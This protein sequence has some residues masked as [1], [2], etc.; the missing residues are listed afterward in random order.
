MISADFLF[1]FHNRLEYYLDLMDQSWGYRP[2]IEV[3]H[4]WLARVD[5]FYDP[6][7]LTINPKTFLWR[8]RVRK[9]FIKQCVSNRTR[10]PA[11][12]AL[13]IFEPHGKLKKAGK[14]KEPYKT[15]GAWLDEFQKE[16]EIMRAANPN[17]KVKVEV[18]EGLCITVDFN[19]EGFAH[20]G[21]T[22]YVTSR[23]AKANRKPESVARMFVAEITSHR[24]TCGDCGVG[25]ATLTCR[26]KGYAW[27]GLDIDAPPDPIEEKIHPRLSNMLKERLKKKG[28]N[29]I[30]CPTKRSN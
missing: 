11:R 16:F 25:I 21:Q 10:T 26:A 12:I 8:H 15:A 14:G 5:A 19:I 23:T 1:R 6:S 13:S 9:F 4:Q 3:S 22:I 28:I 20:K 7:G 24:N 2:Q 29:A 27:M 30:A 18:E 17:Y